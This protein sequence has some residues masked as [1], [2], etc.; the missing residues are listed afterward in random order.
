M[1]VLA[2]SD[3]T[4]SCLANLRQLEGAKSTLALERKMKPGDA[5]ERHMLGE[6]IRDFP[7][8][9]A[10][11]HYTIGAVDAAPVCST[12]GHSEAEHTKE[13]ERRARLERFLLWGSIVSLSVV[14]AYLALVAALRKMSEAR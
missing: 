4:L 13:M 5:V 11:G 2:R 7:N 8:C 10:G 9:P 1:S 3:P 14:T 6:Y 12:P